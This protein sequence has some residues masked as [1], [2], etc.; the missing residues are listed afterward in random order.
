MKPSGSPA[1]TQL[2]LE[3]TLAQWRHWR[4]DP[5]LHG[6]PHLDHSLDGGLSNHN[7]LVSTGSQRFVVRI[8]GV[9]PGRHGMSRQVEF[10][11]QQ[12]AA[13][14]TL[15]PVPRYFNPELGALVCDYI[16]PDD[17]QAFTPA[18]FALLCRKIHALP[19]RRHKLSLDNRIQRYVHLLERSGK[20]LPPQELRQS[21]A[22]QLGSVEAQ[23]FQEVLCHNDLLPANLIVSQGRLFALDWEYVA[24]GNPW[25]DLAIGC[26]GQQYDQD[27]V[28]EFLYHYLKRTPERQDTHQLQLF[29]GLYRYLELLWHLEQSTAEQCSTVMAS[30]LNR[31]EKQLT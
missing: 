27:Q 25:F 21:I 1:P 10:L 29:S 19:S 8:D 11:A 5:P 15:A 12:S 31:L 26:E 3:Q 24:M 30:F 16:N 23:S 6:A 2:K 17:Q 14:E 22:Q 20:P 28:E 9:N 4:C 7:F 13:A 18:D